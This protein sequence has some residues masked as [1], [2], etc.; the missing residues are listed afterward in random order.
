MVKINLFAW[1]QWRVAALPEGW[2]MQSLILET[3]N[4]VGSVD[5]KKNTGLAL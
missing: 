3:D 1:T 4:I 5:I 2:Q